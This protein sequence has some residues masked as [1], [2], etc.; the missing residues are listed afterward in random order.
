MNPSSLDHVALWVADRHALASFCC[1]HLGMHVIEEQDNFTLVGVDAKL[2][3]LTLFDAEGPREPGAL[4]RV[5]LRVRDLDAAAES[6]P[7]A[8]REGDTLLV[9]APE[10]LRL[11]IVQDPGAV[12]FDLAHVVLRVSDPDT[13][14]NALGELGFER[15]DGRLAIADRELRLEPNGEPEGERPLLNHLAMLVDS[16]EQVRDEAESRGIE[17]A[18]WKDAAN[19]LAVFVWGPDRI[20]LEY[21]EHKPGFSLT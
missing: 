1:D 20:K 3:K 7:G 2:G 11:A 15:Q 12:D 5:V 10:G 6:I 17:I 8:R 19:T 21:V 9:D 16:A 4:E 18:D 13:S 14:G